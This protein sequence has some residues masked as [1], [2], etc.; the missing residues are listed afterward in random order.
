M[1]TTTTVIAPIGIGWVLAVI[2]LVVDIVL[3]VTSQVDLKV[4][5]LIGGLAL[6]RLVA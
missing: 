2:V 3:L 5:L 1:Q 4:G 6:A